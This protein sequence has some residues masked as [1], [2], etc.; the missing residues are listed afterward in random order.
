MIFVALVLALEPGATARGGLQVGKLPE[1]QVKAKFLGAL[2]EYV[3][4]PSRPWQA[5]KDRPIV[6]GVV[7]NSPFDQFLDETF[8]RQTIKGH[9]V[10]IVYPKN[11][12]NTLSCDLL[13]IC[14]SEADRIQDILSPLK[15]KPI[16][17]VGD[18]PEFAKKGVMLNF[19][20]DRDRILFEINLNAVRSSGL[21]ISSHV[22]KLAKIVE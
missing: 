17:T 20:M 21:E 9:K 1:Y 3:N 12:Y 22:L 16:L 5:D 7:G 10:R 14:E 4:W 6:L 2:A 11:I 19:F 8:A 13:F 18:S 15:G